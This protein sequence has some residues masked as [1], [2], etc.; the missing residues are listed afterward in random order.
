MKKAC[1]SIPGCK[2]TAIAYCPID[3]DMICREHV[4]WLKKI[5]VQTKFKRISYV[6]GKPVFSEGDQIY[7]PVSGR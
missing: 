2:N 3:K 1:C 4:L 7:V 6:N 5:G